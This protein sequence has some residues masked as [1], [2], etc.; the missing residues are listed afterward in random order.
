V[1]AG[2]PVVD[3]AEEVPRLALLPVGGRVDLDDGG[4]VR[5]GVRAGDLEPDPAVVGDRQQ[6]VD[7]VQ[8]AAGVVREVHAAHRR[9]HLEPE[10]GVVAQARTVSSRCSRRT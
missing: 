8:L 2:W 7:G 6:V 4:D 10:V 9:A 3:D 5:V 1:S